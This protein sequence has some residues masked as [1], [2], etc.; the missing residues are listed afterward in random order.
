VKLSL[1][2]SILTGS[3]NECASS[4]NGGVNLLRGH[5]YAA[6]ALSANDADP[7]GDIATLPAV[8]TGID[9]FLA[10]LTFPFMPEGRARLSV[11]VP[12]HTMR[13][14]RSGLPNSPGGTSAHLQFT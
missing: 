1:I 10:H 7:G 8:V 9:D 6:V 12:A 2:T 5:M 14:T 13:P 4:N 11:T 3:S